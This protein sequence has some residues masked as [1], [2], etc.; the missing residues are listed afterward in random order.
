MCLP[1]EWTL[2]AK[3]PILVASVLTLA[4]VE[5]RFPEKNMKLICFRKETSDLKNLKVRSLLY[6]LVVNSS[7]HILKISSPTKLQNT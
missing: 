6:T 7:Q 5:V 3:E 2:D 4:A 1:T